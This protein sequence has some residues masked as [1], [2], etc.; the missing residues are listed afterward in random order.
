LRARRVYNTGYNSGE[1]SGDVFGGIEAIEGS[2]FG[3]TLVGDFAVNGLLGGGGN[4][5]IDGTGGGDFLYGQA[6]NDS[7]VSR[8]QADAL[9]GG[10][11]FDYAR[12][13]FGDTGL[14][15]YLYDS[16]QNTGFAAGDTYIAVE[17]LAG[18]YF[19]DDLR[20]DANQNIIFGLGGSDF[21]V[22]LGDS[23]L[24][25]GGDG[26]DLFHFIGIG[27]GGANGDVVQD[28]ISGVDRISITGM[29][30]GLGSPNGVPIDSWRF[31]AGTTA[32]VAS[33]QFLWN[34]TSRE[35]FYDADGTGGGAK[36]L[37]ATL[38]GATLAAGDIIVI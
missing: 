33:A 3:D 9:D 23:D 2:A 17:G 22:G 8:Q 4:D 25:I 36:V 20:G 13:D 26:Q 15:A 21:I 31:V 10:A 34:A 37:L 35:L 16:T 18:S 32:T 30:F 19:D 14:K 24:L 12:Y 29:F 1:A 5:W 6:G 27:D 11:D 7:L 38:Q 28:F